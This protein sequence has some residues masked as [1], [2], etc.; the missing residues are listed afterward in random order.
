MNEETSDSEYQD[1]KKLLDGI[2]L[3]GTPG[4]ETLLEETLLKKTPTGSFESPNQRLRRE[5]EREAEKGRKWLQ[6]NY[7]P[8]PKEPRQLKQDPNSGDFT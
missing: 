7:P 3:N 4:K 2:D 6:K 1:W 8:K 5:L